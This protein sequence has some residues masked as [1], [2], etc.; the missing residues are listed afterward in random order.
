ML[1]EM[2]RDPFHQL[3]STG[4]LIL[5]DAPRDDVVTDVLEHA[6]ASLSQSSLWHHES[7]EGPLETV[8]VFGYSDA[9]SISVTKKPTALPASSTLIRS[10]VP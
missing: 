10:P 9:F 8:V 1:P 2:N 3:V 5:V 7:P 4:I 6:L